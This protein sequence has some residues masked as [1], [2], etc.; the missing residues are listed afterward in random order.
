[1]ENNHKS[2]LN[3]IKGKGLIYLV[4]HENIMKAVVEYENKDYD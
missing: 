4:E 2:M 3:F 1:M